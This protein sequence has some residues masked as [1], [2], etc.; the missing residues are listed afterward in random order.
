M[1]IDKL[2][3]SI[4]D[5]TSNPCQAE[6]GEFLLFW[7]FLYHSISNRVHQLIYLIC[8]SYSSTPTV[9]GYRREWQWLWSV[10]AL[11]Q[12]RKGSMGK[13]RLGRFSYSV[14]SRLRRL[15][16]FRWI[17]AMNANIRCWERTSALWHSMVCSGVVATFS[18]LLIPSIIFTSQSI[19]RSNSG[20]YEQEEQKTCEHRRVLLRTSTDP[21]EEGDDTFSPVALSMDSVHL[22]VAK[23]DSERR[24]KE[25]RIRSP[26]TR[27]K[28]NVNVAFSLSRNRFCSFSLCCDFVS[29]RLVS[30][31]EKWHEKKANIH[32]L[33]I[34]SFNGRENA[35]T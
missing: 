8:L 6:D 2:H 25:K 33:M 18:N 32:C 22:N 30:V 10:R 13:E 14:L 16:C 4:D 20:S 12:E 21:N 11:T 5:F 31:N 35:S 23:L 28:T 3:L 17:S 1:F 9:Y 15:R 29:L 26:S 24:E 27:T 34:K 19:F 7:K